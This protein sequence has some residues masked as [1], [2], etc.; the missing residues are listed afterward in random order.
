MTIST[1]T[2]I[3]QESN[4]FAMDDMRSESWETAEK[5]WMWMKLVLD[6]SWSDETLIKLIDESSEL[7]VSSLEPK[8]RQRPRSLLR[9]Q[10]VSVP[11]IK[12]LLAGQRSYGAPSG[13][14]PISVVH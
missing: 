9:R 11:E 1:H 8:H 12:L 7:T 5:S 4:S 3:E 13:S 2:E 6:G 10:S 14:V